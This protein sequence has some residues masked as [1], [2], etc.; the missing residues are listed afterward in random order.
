M[1]FGNFEM[2]DDLFLIMGVFVCIT[3]IAI[4]ALIVLN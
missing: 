3:A 4:T 2:D 1:K